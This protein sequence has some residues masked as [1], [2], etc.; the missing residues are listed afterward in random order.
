MTVTAAG[1]AA[2]A[3]V[4]QVM[5]V[6]AT[7]TEVAAVPPM[8]TVAPARNPLPVMVIAVP[9]ATGPRPGVTAVMV[10]AGS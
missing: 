6:A 9:P 10:G 5:V 7:T 2:P 1:P 4:V 3:G 8:A